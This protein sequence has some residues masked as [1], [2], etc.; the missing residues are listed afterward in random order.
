M[1]L[2]FSLSLLSTKTSHGDIRHY[3]GAPQPAASPS[4]VRKIQRRK[5]DIALGFRDPLQATEVRNLSAV[6]VQVGILLVVVT[7]SSA[8]QR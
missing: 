1:E 7:S 6:A 4:R 2:R 8:V 3:D 5:A